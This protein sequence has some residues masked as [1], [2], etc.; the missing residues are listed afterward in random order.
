MSRYKDV[1]VN[2]VHRKEHIVVWEKFHGRSVPHGCVIHHKDGNGHNNDPSNLVCLTRSE[3]HRLHRQLR[4]EGRDVIDEK[5]PDVIIARQ[6]SSSW[7]KSHP[8]Q[9]KTSNSR[10]RETHREQLKRSAKEYRRTHANEIKIRENSPERKL[11]RAATKRQYYFEHKS[12]VNLKSAEYYASHRE[13]IM[14]K[15]A[16]YRKIH[17]ES[18]AAK[19]NLKNAILRGDCEEKIALLRRKVDDALKREME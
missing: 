9:V 13:E 10:Y 5:D 18:I 2:G 3:H 14:K 12:E 4:M 16:E 8:D 11:K 7:S 1:T 6:Q 15:K 17:R 19:A